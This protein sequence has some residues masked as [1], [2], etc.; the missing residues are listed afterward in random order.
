MV[1]FQGQCV[2][3]SM[4]RRTTHFISKAT[5]NR[6]FEMGLPKV[7]PAIRFKLARQMFLVVKTKVMR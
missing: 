7:G 5:D 6:W 2:I 1:L 4:L 3:L